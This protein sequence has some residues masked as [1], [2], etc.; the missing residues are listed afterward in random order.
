MYIFLCGVQW[1]IYLCKSTPYDKYR[2]QKLSICKKNKWYLY[3]ISLFAA[4]KSINI[5]LDYGGSEGGNAIWFFFFFFPLCVR[6]QKVTADTEDECGLTIHKHYLL[7]S[8]PTAILAC[9]NFSWWPNYLFQVAN[10][11]FVQRRHSSACGF[12]LVNFSWWMKRNPIYGTCRIQ[13]I[14]WEWEKW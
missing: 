1:L 10:R 11:I 14:W 12:L 2:I 3:W 4:T 5:R 7:P 6:L 9:S 13:T 8:C